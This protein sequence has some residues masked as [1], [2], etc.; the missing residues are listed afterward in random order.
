MT[1]LHDKLGLVAGVVRNVGR[2]V[3]P[4]ADTVAAIRLVHSKACAVD[5]LGDCAAQIPVEGAWLAHVYGLEEGIM[6]RLDEC[7]LLIRNV[8][9]DDEGLVEV[10]VIAVEHRR[11]IDVDDVAVFELAHVWYSVADD[12][13]D[14]GADRLWEV[15]VMQRRR[16]R[17]RLDGCIMNDPVD[18]IRRNAWPDDAVSGVQNLAAEEACLAHLTNLLRRQHRRRVPRFRQSLRL[19]LTRRIV[20]GLWDVV[21]NWPVGRDA[22]RHEGTV[23]GKVGPLV[24][25]RFPMVQHILPG[26]AVLDILRPGG[27]EVLAVHF[28]RREFN[29]QH[30]DELIFFLVCLASLLQALNALC[31][32]N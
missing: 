28:A 4:L 22:V 6:R 26:A 20:V 14:R 11:D 19:R 30:S 21:G 5:V 17:S 18:L 9:A 2:A 15:K 7:L 1:R 8:V 27:S 12:F 13:V 25:A 10:G 3:E 16:V 24:T 29:Q 31:T 23:V 32:L